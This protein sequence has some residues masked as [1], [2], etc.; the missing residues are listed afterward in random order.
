MRSEINAFN[1]AFERPAIKALI[2]EVSG[3]RV[4]DAAC[5]GGTLSQWLVECGAQV[6]ALDVTSEMVS[7]ARQR[8]GE[9]ALVLQADLAQRLPFGDG[10][11]DVIVSSFT[12]HYLRDWHFVL[13]E[14][15]RALRPDGALVVST[16]HPS[17]DVGLSASGDYFQTELLEDTWTSFGDTPV[18]VHF[19]RRPLC[20]MSQALYDAGFLIER[21]EERAPREFAAFKEEHARVGNRPVYLFFR[22]IPRR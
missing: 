10:S 4:L 3:L 17:N 6:V 21:I 8:L 14:F 13:R 22:A 19:F 11:F 1:G 15:R 9:R 2:G 12:L 5:A 16:H 18:Q 7:F 20:D